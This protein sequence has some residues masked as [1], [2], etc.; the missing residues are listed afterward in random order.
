MPFRLEKSVSL[1]HFAFAV[2]LRM[3]DYQANRL[4]AGQGLP[5]SLESQP[6]GTLGAGA[7]WTGMSLD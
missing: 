7:E 4:Q 5:A 2:R 6:N 1:D 3:E